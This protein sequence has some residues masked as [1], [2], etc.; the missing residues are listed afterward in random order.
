MKDL[1]GENIG[2]ELGVDDQNHFH[3]R[4]QRQ[5]HNNRLQ[6]PLQNQLREQL[7]DPLVDN[8]W[9]GLLVGSMTRLTAARG[10]K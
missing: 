9:D 8:L 1:L 7:W 5:H 3:G 10:N 4:L 2:Y 6:A